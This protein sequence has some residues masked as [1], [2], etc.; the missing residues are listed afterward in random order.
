M[1]GMA[2]GSKMQ[3]KCKVRGG[4]E[5]QVKAWKKEGWTETEKG[6]GNKPEV[7]SR[8]WRECKKERR[9]RKR[10][11]RKGVSL[12]KH[13][14]PHN[15]KLVAK[16]WH[17][18]AFQETT[19]RSSVRASVYTHVCTFYI[20]SGTVVHCVYEDVPTAP[21][22]TLGNQTCMF[23]TLWAL[24]IITL[25]LNLFFFQYESERPWLPTGKRN[26]VCL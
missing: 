4:T 10:L 6:L 20:R 15:S 3:N 14:V 13:P 23:L 17:S 22:M 7:R 25:K 9:G 8:R 12:G 16:F 5:R 11:K 18:F 21:K 19:V 2:T 24:A 26:E 1:G